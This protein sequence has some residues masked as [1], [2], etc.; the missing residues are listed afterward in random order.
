SR[1]AKAAAILL[2]A[3]ALSYVWSSHRI[4]QPPDFAALPITWPGHLIPY[5]RVSYPPAQPPV[6]HRSRRKDE[7]K[8]HNIFM[9]AIDRVAHPLRQS[10]SKASRDPDTN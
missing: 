9:R 5:Q 4:A 7:G 3:V 10:N 1:M 2:C 6:S 8:N